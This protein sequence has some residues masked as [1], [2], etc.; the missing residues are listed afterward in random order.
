LTLSEVL[1]H[2]A[3]LRPFSPFY[4]RLMKNGQ[5]IPGIAT[6]TADESHQMRVAEGIYINRS[7][8]DS[9]IKWVLET[10][11]T[12]RGKYVY[13]D[14]GMYLLMRLVER[15]SGM[16]FD[17]FLEKNYYAPL[18]L[19]TLGYRPYLRFPLDRIMPTEN[20][21]VFRHE[22]VHGDV[23]D[24]GAALMGGV[25]GHAGL[26]SDANDLAIILQMLLNGGTYGGTRYLRASTIDAFTTCR[27]CTGD[28][29]TENRRGL[30]WDRPQAP[31]EPGPASGKV[32]ILSF[33]HTGFTGTIVWADPADSSIYIF[34]SNRVYPSAATNLLAHMNTRTDIQGV[35]HDAIAARYKK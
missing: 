6:D 21:T 12:E 8:R 4:L 17:R 15:V 33:G 23:H 13:S 31:G 19:A 11:T 22:Q 7:Y 1:A 30:G 25:A 14:L 18:G 35:V 26:F 9:L 5:F 2:Q 16:P 24:P 28:R 3:G 10:P 34:L 29:K 27:Y 20:D 32:S